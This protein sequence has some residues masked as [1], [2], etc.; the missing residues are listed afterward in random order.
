MN[1]FVTGG[2]GYLGA[3]LTQTL[4][5]LG[6]EVTVIDAG[7]HGCNLPPHP[8]LTLRLADLRDLTTLDLA[9]FDAVIHLASIADP[10]TAALNPDLVWETN[11]GATTFLVEHAINAGVPHFI[12]CSAAAVYGNTLDRPRTEADPVVIDGPL[13]QSLVH[14]ERLLQSYHRD[15][16]VDIVRPG[17][18]CGVSPR[19]RLDLPVNLYAMQALTRGRI[20]VNGATETATHTHLRDLIRLFTT[21]LDRHLPAGLFNAGFE[22]CT[23]L[24]LAL[25]VAAQIPADL[26]VVQS[27]NPQAAQLDSS[28]LTHFGF[29][30]TYNL[31]DAIWEIAAEYRMGRLREQENHYNLP[32]PATPHLVV[33]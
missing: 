19:M 11:V 23:H 29:K 17:F 31:D 20:T 10:D 18:V 21:L 6:H 27:E 30:P 26:E 24:D 14:A 16:R 22:T 1:L 8:N 33:A 32:V 15:L 3:P 5:A 12:H 7:F 9:E 2:C 28:R 25:R 4:L 13:T